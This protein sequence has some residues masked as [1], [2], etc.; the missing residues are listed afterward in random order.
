MPVVGPTL[1]SAFVAE[2]EGE[3]KA[4]SFPLILSWS[5]PGSSDLSRKTY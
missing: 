1:Q 5:F 2:P 3:G 4:P